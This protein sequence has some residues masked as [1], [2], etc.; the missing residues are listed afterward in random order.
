MAIVFNSIG[1]LGLEG[2][3]INV[4]VSIYNDRA[5]IIGILL[6]SEQIYPQNFN[7]REYIFLGE[8][9]LNGELKNIHGVLPMVIAAKKKGFTKIILPS[10]CKREGSVVGGMEIYSFDNINQIIDFM[11]KNI[12]I[13]SFIEPQSSTNEMQEF[14]IDF[15]DVYGNRD[16][17][18]YVA[19]AAAGNHNFLMVGAPGCGKSMIA[20]RMPTILPQMTE[21]EILE[22]TFIYSICGPLK[23]SGLITSRPFRAPHYNASSNVLIGG[24]MNGISG[25]ILDRIDIQ[26][27]MG[28]V[29]LFEDDGQSKNL[30][31]AEIKEKVEMARNIQLER[32]KNIKGINSNGQMESAHIKVFCQLD[33]DSLNLLQ[34]S[35]EKFQ[36]SAR[37][38]NKIIKISRTFADI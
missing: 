12:F 2:Y 13:K 10:S 3:L 19:A 34:R 16:I 38:H 32:F 37:T 15:K 25:P 36:F 24:G 11:E 28:K 17:I 26:K 23:D 1:I 21:E 27:Y 22:T 30:T 18:E 20:K 33:T 29:N 7:M 9:S 31:S 5:I 4:E 14:K 35:Y 6:E 8:I